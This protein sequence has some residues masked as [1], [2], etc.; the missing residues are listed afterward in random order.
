M[1]KRKAFTMIE[2][3]F[4]MAIMSFFMIAIAF[5]VNKKVQ[6][7][8]SA[9]TGGAFY[10]YK[11]ESDTLNQR[12]EIFYG[13]TKKVDEAFGVDM[14]TFDLPASVNDFTVQLIGGGGG[15]S[16]GRVGIAN[17]V[18]HR[19]LSN[20]PFPC[21]EGH[22][23][24]GEIL[25]S[26]SVC[27]E[28]ASVP[29]CTD[30]RNDVVGTAITIPDNLSAYISQDVYNQLFLNNISVVAAGGSDMYSNSGA[31]CKKTNNY[32]VGDVVSCVRS[33]V[34]ETQVAGG[35]HTGDKK[36]TS[37]SSGFLNI[38]GTNVMTAQAKVAY[39]YKSTNDDFTM[40]STSCMGDDARLAAGDS[41]GLSG[42]K[43]YS[44]EVVQSLEL[45]PGQ[46][47]EA[48]GYE[49]RRVGADAIS[50]DRRVVIN[51]A[52]V[53]DGGDAGVGNASGE[54]GG[55]TT[56][57]GIQAFGG[58]GGLGLGAPVVSNARTLE[59]IPVSDSN[60]SSRAHPNSVFVSDSS[61]ALRGTVPRY[62]TDENVGV[63]RRISNAQQQDYYSAM[64][65]CEIIGDDFGCTNA[66]QPKALAFGVGGSA[67]AS[68]VKYDSIVKLSVND[69]GTV[70]ST[71]EHRPE[72]AF[73]SGAKGTGGAI[74]ISW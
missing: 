51:S 35:T 68:A 19:N 23:A 39:D 24:A 22:D 56:L 9:P 5:S 34:S 32:K 41:I 67:G 43:T 54:R 4:S 61:D 66:Q 25:G 31:T 37:S 14:C 69:G 64:G 60:L 47:G 62:Y 71:P 2:L 65:V 27:E 18:N 42:V 3:I 38:N 74:I 70:I 20:A 72:G 50:V 8:V 15:A 44:F 48:G 57:R 59:I 26:Y 63:F 30:Y 7:R 17:T 58:A 52:D 16:S 10:C 40:A 53:G 1:T 46:S 13:D 29:S 36:Y 28:F 45:Y 6:Q 12:T 49:S 21:L 73:S 55:T 11:N 33:G